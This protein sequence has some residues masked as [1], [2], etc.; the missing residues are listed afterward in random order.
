MDLAFTYSIPVFRELRPWVKLEFYNVFNNQNLVG[1]NVQVTP[2]PGGPVDANGLPLEM[3]R[4]PSSAA[5]PRMR[6]SR[7]RRRISRGRTSMPGRSWD[8]SAS[9]SDCSSARRKEGVG[10]LLILVDEVVQHA[11]ADDQ[12][13]V[14]IERGVQE[15]GRI[16]AATRSHVAIR[17]WSEGRAGPLR[18][19]CTP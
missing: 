5:R 9:A 16:R 13:E 18:P 6:A 14:A 15:I 7:G 10:P 8:R 2:R 1:H 3:S 11:R 12:I 19:R 17:A 4:A